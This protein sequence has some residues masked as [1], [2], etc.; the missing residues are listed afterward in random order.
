MPVASTDFAVLEAR[1][2]TLWR[3]ALFV[4]LIPVTIATHWPRLGFGAGGPIDKFSHFLG[5]GFL[6]WI[7]LHAVPQRRAW[8][9][10]LA[11]VAW[12]YIDERTQAIP[13][14]GRVFSVHDMIAGWLGVICAGALF[15]CRARAL[16]SD[17]RTR[18]VAMTYGKLVHWFAAAAITLVVVLLL[19]GAMFAFAVLHGAPAVWP[20]AVYPV[21]FSGLV[22]IALATGIVER[23][24]TRDV[25]RPRRSAWAF[26]LVVPVTAMLYGAYFALCFVLFGREPR[27]ELASDAEGFAFLR[28]TMLVV[29]AL[30]ALAFAHACVRRVWPVQSTRAAQD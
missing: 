8:L 30:I 5:F 10:W 20:V 16:P 24:A 12:V 13:I 3:T 15:A 23:V 22:G 17:V 4:Y 2:R 28:R 11:A 9:A 14:L 1:A 19:G 26:L 6:A 21:G 27:E 29:C 18:V 7:A 25:A